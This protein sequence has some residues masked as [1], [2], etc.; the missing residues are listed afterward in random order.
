MELAD[1]GLYLV[2]RSGRNAW[3]GI[4]G[5]QETQFGELFPR[6]IH[7]LDQSLANGEARLV[8]SLEQV[9]MTAGA[10]TRRV[11]GLA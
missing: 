9:Q 3:A 2:K 11:V 8:T 10:K 4:Y 5:T 6:L 1:Q 7:H